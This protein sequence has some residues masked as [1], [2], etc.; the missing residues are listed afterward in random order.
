ML[1]TICGGVRLLDEVTDEDRIS[2]FL[3]LREFVKPNQGWQKDLAPS[4]KS[5]AY[6]HHRRIWSARRDPAAGFFQS[7]SD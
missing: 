7:D 6:L 2:I 5:P 3:A 1:K 4:G